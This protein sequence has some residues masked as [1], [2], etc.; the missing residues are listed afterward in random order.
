MIPIETSSRK[1][2]NESQIKHV[3]ELLDIKYRPDAH[4]LSIVEKQHKGS[5]NWLTESAVFQKWLGSAH[6]CGLDL[7]EE[8]AQLDLGVRSSL[9]EMADSERALLGD[10]DMIWHTLFRNH[11]FRIESLKPQFWVID[12]LDECASNDLS[13]LLHMLAKLDA[14]IPLRI[15]FTS[16]PDVQIKKIFN[17][18]GA[19]ISDIRTGSQ[20]SLS[21]ISSSTEKSDGIFLWAS[22]I[23]NRLNEAYSQEDMQEILEQV[24]S[25]MNGFYMRIVNSIAESQSTDLARCILKWIICAARP[26]STDELREAVHADI[27]KSL[28]ASDDKLDLLCGNLIRVDMDGRVQVIH[29]TVTAFLTDN[30][31]SL[32]IDTIASHSRLAE[33]RESNMS[34]LTRVSDK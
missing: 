13:P 27:K 11:L 22:L 5:C 2:E 33:G 7:A 30:A 1:D 8:M 23:V 20:G 3:S 32:R 4:L 9:A 12:A 21:D 6:D 28:T 25:E 14:S 24:P 19:L 17:Q 10:H 31:S 18:H 15:F 26:L 29:Q 34:R 16:R